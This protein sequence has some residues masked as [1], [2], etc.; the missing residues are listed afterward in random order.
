[1]QFMADEG[2]RD[3][4]RHFLQRHSLWYAAQGSFKQTLTQTVSNPNEMH[5]VMWKIR[6]TVH[7]S[8]VLGGHRSHKY[9]RG[10]MSPS[11]LAG[12]WHTLAL[13]H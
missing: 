6:D 13:E 7:V 4:E 12:D 2:W 9:A 11:L 8:G 1:M 3:T 10:A 5:W